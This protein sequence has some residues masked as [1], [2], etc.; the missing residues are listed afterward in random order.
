MNLL[1]TLLNIAAG[2]IA[3]SSAYCWIKSSRVSVKHP[4]AKHDGIFHDMSVSLDG[5]DFFPTARL[6]GT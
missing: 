4:H 1:I 3:M 5:M 6:Q 2:L